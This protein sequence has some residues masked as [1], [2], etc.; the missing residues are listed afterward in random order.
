M[1]KEEC[2]GQSSVA[3]ASKTGSLV[4]SCTSGVHPTRGKKSVANR[5]SLEQSRREDRSKCFEAI[6]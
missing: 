4:G 6:V 5:S 2:Q 1:Q 3:E